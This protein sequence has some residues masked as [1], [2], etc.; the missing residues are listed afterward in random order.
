MTN[1]A[2][3][4]LTDRLT[5]CDPVEVSLLAAQAC[6]HGISRAAL[7]AARDRVGVIASGSRYDRDDPVRWALP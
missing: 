1:R 2:A 7:Y 6:R 5:G 3:T 4:W